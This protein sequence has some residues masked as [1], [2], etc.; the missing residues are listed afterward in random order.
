MAVAEV[1]VA[2]GVEAWEVTGDASLVG[3]D[4]HFWRFSWGRLDG[5]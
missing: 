1:V 5:V 3:L 2:G 4:M